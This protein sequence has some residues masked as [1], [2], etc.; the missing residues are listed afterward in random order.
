MSHRWI[1]L[2][3]PLLLA[4]GLAR[5]GDAGGGCDDLRGTPI[6]F[7]V[8]W[9]SEVKPI[10]NETLGQMGRCTS[11]HHSGLD[12]RPPDL[13]DEDADAIYKIVGSFVI[14]GRP[15]DSLLFSKV[16]CAQ[17]FD[18]RARMPADGGPLTR[19]QQEL[20]HDWIAQGALGEPVDEPITPRREFIFRDGIESLR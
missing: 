9:A 4:P 2:L 18:G 19:E 16:N 13:T 14:P 10:L 17:P 15:Q 3:F 1:R 7:A 11:C 20:I 8:D 6:H 12:G 5:P